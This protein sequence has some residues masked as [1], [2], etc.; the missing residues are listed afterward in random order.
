MSIDYDYKDFL[1]ETGN[2]LERSEML[3]TGLFGE[4]D[5]HC[6]LLQ[7]EREWRKYPNRRTGITHVRNREIQSEIDFMQMS[8]L[9]DIHLTGL[10]PQIEMDDAEYT[11]K[12][13]IDPRTFKT[14]VVH[15]IGPRRRRGK[16]KAPS[17][18]PTDSPKDLIA[19]YEKED[20][21]RTEEERK[22]A[23]EKAARQKEKALRL[24]REE[25]ERYK[26]KK[27]LEAFTR[28]EKRR[29]AAEKKALIDA[30]RIDIFTR[31]PPPRDASETIQAIYQMLAGG[32]LRK[33][34]SQICTIL[35]TPMSNLVSTTQF[36]L[37][38]LM[39]VLILRYAALLT[40]NGITPD[41][42]HWKHMMLLTKGDY[43]KQ[44]I[45]LIRDAIRDNDKD[46]LGRES[47]LKFKINNFNIKIHDVAY[48]RRRVFTFS[49]LDLLPQYNKLR[50]HKK[51]YCHLWAHV[52][53][54]SKLKNCWIWQG[55]IFN[56]GLL[57]LYGQY[58]F[59][60][61]YLAHE[62]IW[63]SYN[64]TIKSNQFLIHKCLNRR[65]VNPSHM[66]IS[67]YSV[68]TTLEL[69]KLEL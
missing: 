69:M 50:F 20:R 42:P 54:P 40:K 32:P 52:H 41:S 18:L 55:P 65:C 33:N 60:G 2:R 14:I 3:S 30:M 31:K 26:R 24:K 35:N 7:K 11:G 53:I 56:Q 47:I 58:N 13:S 25:Y 59:H 34:M 38:R 61:R 66:M 57:E 48:W 28:A 23:E 45:E 22:R 21:R 4:I 43:K 63:C 12:E 17:K 29:Q 49:M 8:E 15:H 68:D 51:D 44:R 39:T 27:E 67:P 64:G 9:I 46:I 62:L 1:L 16:R 6:L 10:V 37:S 19:Y 5:K 36:P